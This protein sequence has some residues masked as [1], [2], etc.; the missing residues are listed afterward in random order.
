MTAVLLLAPAPGAAEQPVWFQL[1]PIALILGIMYFLV[2]APARKQRKEA[3]AMLDA[4]R[5]GD[6]VLTSGGLHG[7]VVGVEGDLVKLR[8]ATNVHVEL[9]KTA[10]T[11]RI[12]AGPGEK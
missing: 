12:E 10:V 2:I 9:A 3:Q 4:L 6:R 8:I 1:I 5:P 11:S 7:T